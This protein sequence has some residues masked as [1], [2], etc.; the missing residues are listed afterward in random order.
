[1]M[2]FR[3]KRRL[4]PRVEPQAFAQGPSLAVGRKARSA[5]PSA[6][7]HSCL[8]R[9]ALDKFLLYRFARRNLS[10]NALLPRQ[11]RENLRNLETQLTIRGHC[12]QRQTPLAAAKRLSGF[13]QAPSKPGPSTSPKP[14]RHH[15]A[16]PAIFGPSR[17]SKPFRRPGQISPRT[18]ASKHFGAIGNADRSENLGRRT[19]RTRTMTPPPP[20]RAGLDQPISGDGI[21]LPCPGFGPRTRARFAARCSSVWRTAS[22][23]LRITLGK[24]SLSRPRSDTK[25]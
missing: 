7:A 16:Q 18:Q 21:S 22:I 1:M 6:A 14:R 20:A 25:R 15:A 3:S 5:Q 10:R 8:G 23:T 9:R 12:L 19:G 24:A 13:E 11:D 2:R 4:K 17:S